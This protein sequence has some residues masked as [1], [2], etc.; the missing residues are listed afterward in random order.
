MAEDLVNTARLP[1]PRPLGD[2]ETMESLSHW[3]TTFRNYYRRDKYVG[4]FL[5]STFKWDPSKPHYGFEDE[6][7]GLKRAKADLADDLTGFM[8]IISS[9]M[10]NSYITERLKTSTKN[11]EDVKKCLFALYD[12][13]LSQDT[14]LDL[15]SPI[16]A[17]KS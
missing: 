15:S 9:H 2:E 10:K 5:I 6:A 14:F 8:E 17:S 13:E 1:V 12:A 7:T 3:W 4:G 11:I 16:N